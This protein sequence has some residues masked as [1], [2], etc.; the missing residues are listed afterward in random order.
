M[1]EGRGLPRTVSQIYDERTFN[2]DNYYQ[3]NDKL[4]NWRVDIVGAFELD[5]VLIAAIP[6]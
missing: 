6:H 5:L 3:S 2:E 4:S 1:C